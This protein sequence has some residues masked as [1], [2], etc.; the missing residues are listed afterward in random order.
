MAKRYKIT[1]E[2]GGIRL[3][4]PQALDIIERLNS[5]QRQL[6]EAD[7][8]LVKMPVL[9]AGDAGLV[10]TLADD[11][12]RCLILAVNDLADAV[13]VSSNIR[14]DAEEESDE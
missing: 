6:A 9:A 11:A 2:P 12:I 13:A 14:I 5:V 7:G 8:A 10:A 1:V 4:S 3:P